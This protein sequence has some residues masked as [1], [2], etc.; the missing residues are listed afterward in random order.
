MYLEQICKL[1]YNKLIIFGQNTFNLSE[2]YIL[3]PFLS[4]FETFENLKNRHLK[5]K[6]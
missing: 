3:K 4:I 5:L 1:L 2:N 6:T